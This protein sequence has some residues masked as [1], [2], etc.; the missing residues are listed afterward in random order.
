MSDVSMSLWNYC[1][2][3]YL[4]L[5]EEDLC[6]FS[7]L[8]KITT[9][10]ISFVD[11]LLNVNTIFFLL[12]KELA[13]NALDSSQKSNFVC[14]FYYRSHKNVLNVFRI[15]QPKLY[16]NLVLWRENSVNIQRKCSSELIVV[17]FLVLKIILL[18]AVQICI[19]TIIV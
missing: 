8:N 15:H 14:L 18:L 17:L 11:K 19:T 5:N 9:T 6:I 16:I 13:N 4:Y 2:I 3:T 1:L 7:V 10:Y 12:Q